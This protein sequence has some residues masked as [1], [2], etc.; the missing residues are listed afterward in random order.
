MEIV[1]LGKTKEKIS[2]LLKNSNATFANSL[3][4]AMISEV[5]VLAIEDVELRKNSSVL[6]DEVIAHRLGL[7]PIKTDLKSYVLP[8]DCSCK[9]EGCARCRLKM[10]LKARGPG[11]VYASDIKSKDSKCTPVYPETPIVKLLKGQEL[12]LEATAVLGEG[13]EHAKW[14]P[15][16]VWYRYKP[17]VT[18]NQDRVKKHIEEITKLCPSGVF[19]VKSGR[20]NVNDKLLTENPLAGEQADAVASKYNGIVFEESDTDFI[21]HLESWGQLTPR[22]IVLKAADVLQKKMD[23]FVK[24]LK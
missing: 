13:K 10:T 19:V 1:S 3:R 12:E 20:L 15:G 8:R 24:L 5:P 21:F 6:Y 2:F 16:L 18:I 9:G 11:L 14:S 4:R 7:L 22:E 23:V 17:K